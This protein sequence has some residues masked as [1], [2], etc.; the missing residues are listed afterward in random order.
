M[1]AAILRVGLAHLAAWTER[2]RALARALPAR[3]RGRA[4]PGPARGA[5]LRPGGLP[6]LRGA[7]RAARRPG[8]GPQGAGLGTL[9]HYPIPLHLQPAL[10]AARREAG[11]LP[12]GREGRAAR[13]S[14]CPSTRSSPT[15]RRALVCEA[16]REACGR[17]LVVNLGPAL[18]AV[19]ARARPLPRPRPRSSWPCCPSDE[20]ERTPLDEAL[21]LAV[22][23]ER[24]RLGLGGAAPRRGW[25]ASPCPRAAGLAGRG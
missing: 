9:I 6:P 16:V 1:Q 24:R 15:R 21:F 2:R 12:G 11:R 23:G 25:R 22:G 10:R 5:A 13:S 3:A 20:R 18:P 8:R 14:P 7:P 17:C 19:L 4:R